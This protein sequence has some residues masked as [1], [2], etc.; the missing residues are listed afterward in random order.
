MSKDKI[1][2]N[3]TFYSAKKISEIDLENGSTT[4]DQKNMSSSK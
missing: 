2:N 1:Q 3:S 4:K